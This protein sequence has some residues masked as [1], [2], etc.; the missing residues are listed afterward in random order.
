MPWAV[1]EDLNA[2][3]HILIWVD[4]PRRAVGATIMERTSLHPAG[5]V[6]RLSPFFQCLLYDSIVFSYTAKVHLSFAR[7][8]SKVPQGISRLSI[9]D[10]IAQ[11]PKYR[12]HQIDWIDGL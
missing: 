10:K 3:A 5:L 8:K 7:C 11:I 2:K 12:S 4:G 1:P 6:V 9:S